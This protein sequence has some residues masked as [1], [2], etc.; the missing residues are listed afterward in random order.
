MYN[1]GGF[2]YNTSDHIIRD[3]M[4]SEQQHNWWSKPQGLP[5]WDLFSRTEIKFGFSCD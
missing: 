4:S 2:T 1:T 3:V 5:Q